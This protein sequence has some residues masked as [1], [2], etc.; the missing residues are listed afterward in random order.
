[1]GL[2]GNPSCFNLTYDESSLQEENNIFTPRE[3]EIIK[4]LAKGMSS[5]EIAKQLSISND[6]VKNHRKHILEK[7][8]CKNMVQ[9][10]REMTLN[11]V[12]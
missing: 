4:L 3:M 1:M 5:A 12:I 11:G 8:E 7:A 6:T 2:G 9:L 10:V